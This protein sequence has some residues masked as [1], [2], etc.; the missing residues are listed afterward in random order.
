LNFRFWKSV[1]SFNITQSKKVPVLQSSRAI[2]GKSLAFCSGG[3][4]FELAARQL[5]TLNDY[6]FNFRHYLQVTKGMIY[7]NRP[8]RLASKSFPALPSAH[9]IDNTVWMKIAYL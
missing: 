5:L 8:R 6:I 2:F 9:W 3:Q 1:D 4:Q 7:L